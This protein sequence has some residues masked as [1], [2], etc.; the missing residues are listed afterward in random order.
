ML[1]INKLAFGDIVT[2]TEHDCFNCDIS[3]YNCRILNVYTMSEIIDV[4]PVKWNALDEEWRVCAQSDA[5]HT[6]I[7]WYDDDA[8]L[9]M[10]FI[11]VKTCKNLYLLADA[12]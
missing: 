10:V 8:E 1:N 2:F 5:T 3:D 4:S 9:H 12:I 7:R 6:L 11:D